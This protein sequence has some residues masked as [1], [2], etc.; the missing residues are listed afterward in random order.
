[1]HKQNH[2]L[3]MKNVA[4]LNR[5]LSEAYDLLLTFTRYANGQ[6]VPG[7]GTIDK[8]LALLDELGATEEEV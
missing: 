5:Q 3:T 7:S 1:M 6:S 4:I 8:S 2:E